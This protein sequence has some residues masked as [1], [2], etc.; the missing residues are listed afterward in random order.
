MYLLP[1]C[2]N[3]ECIHKKVNYHRTQ[4]VARR[5]HYNIHNVK[6]FNY[7]EYY[8]TSDISILTMTR[9]C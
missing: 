6:L 4:N 8:T 5:K 7:E 1:Y 3:L 2:Y 9:S